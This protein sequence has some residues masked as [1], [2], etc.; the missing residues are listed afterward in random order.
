MSRIDYELRDAQLRQ[1]VVA[2]EVH[3]PSDGQEESSRS[4]GPLPPSSD[5]E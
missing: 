1:R 4:N 3:G 2:M 5:E